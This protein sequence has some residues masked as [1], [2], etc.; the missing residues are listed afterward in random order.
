MHSPQQPESCRAAVWPLLHPAALQPPHSTPRSPTCP[1]SPRAAHSSNDAAAA[2]GAGFG[3]WLGCNAGGAE[4]GA[5]A[6]A[7]HRAGPALIT[8]PAVLILDEATSQVPGPPGQDPLQPGRRPPPAVPRAEARSLPG[9]VRSHAVRSVTTMGS[10]VDLSPSRSGYAQPLAHL[11][12][13]SSTGPM[14]STCD[15]PAGRG[16]RLPLRR[17]VECAELERDCGC[18]YPAGR[19]RR[20]PPRRQVAELELDCGCYY[21]SVAMSIAW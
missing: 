11:A 21:P 16:P 14:L 6:A 13:R 15:D 20:L 19:G 18:Y 17:Q 9:A 2:R 12:V 4:R 1:S 5:A 10:A 3:G 8:D 7:E